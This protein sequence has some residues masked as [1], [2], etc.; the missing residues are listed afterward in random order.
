MTNEE[1][2]DLLRTLSV[3]TASL[4][5]VLP[6]IAGTVGRI[7]G[8]GL[9]LAADFVAAGKDPIA[10]ITRLRKVAPMLADVE[11]GW[12]A[13]LERRWPTTP[14]LADAPDTLEDVYEDDEG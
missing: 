9:G 8:A 6:G 13:E 7:I 1:Y 4:S 2:R 12:E 5:A 14:G 11:K 10:Q 3:G